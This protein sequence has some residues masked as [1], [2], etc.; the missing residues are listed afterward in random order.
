MFADEESGRRTRDYHLKRDARKTLSLIEEADDAAEDLFKIFRFYMNIHLAS[1]K[2]QLDQYWIDLIPEWEMDHFY[3][4]NEVK[5]D[6]HH[7]LAVPVFSVGALWMHKKGGGEN[8]HH[9][10][11][12]QVIEIPIGKTVTYS[13]GFRSE[14]LLTR[15]YEALLDDECE[16]CVVLSSAAVEREFAEIYRRIKHDKSIKLNPVVKLPSPPKSLMKTLK[17]WELVMINHANALGE[18]NL[19]I[20]KLFKKQKFQRELRN[21]SLHNGI[22]VKTYIERAIKGQHDYYPP[23]KYEVDVPRDSSHKKPKSYQ[24]RVVD[25][26]HRSSWKMRELLIHFRTRYLIEDV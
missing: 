4:Q 13:H 9:K 11:W 24:W 12:E 3:T 17:N 22:T 7:I 16:I 6:G 21:K 19:E 14:G 5:M 18:S 8:I 1:I 10:Q 23:T 25:D 20:R 15:A 26:L 2:Y